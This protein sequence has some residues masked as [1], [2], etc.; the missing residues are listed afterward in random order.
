MSIPFSLISLSQNIRSWPDSSSGPFLY[1]FKDGAY[2]IT[3]NDPAR[4]AT[5]ILPGEYLDRPFV[6]TLTMDEIRG[7]DT[8]VNNEFGMILRFNSQV[9]NGKQITTF[10]YL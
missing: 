3:N 1:L 9:K 6:Y 4:V 5:A 2:H 7:D 8:S 10:L